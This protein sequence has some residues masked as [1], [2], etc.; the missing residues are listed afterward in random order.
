MVLSPMD[1]NKAEMDTVW[2]QG[3]SGNFLKAGLTWF[4]EQMTCE[5]RSL[6]SGI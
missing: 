1:K 3:E 2:L 5:Q 6:T 4:I